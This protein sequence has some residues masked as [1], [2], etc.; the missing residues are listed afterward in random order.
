MGL[1]EN[2]AIAESINKIFSEFE[3]RNEINQYQ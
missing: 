3:M 1:V 2:F